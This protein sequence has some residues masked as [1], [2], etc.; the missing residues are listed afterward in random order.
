MILINVKFQPLP[1]NVD[2]FRELVTDFTDATRA[3]DGCLF[4]DWYRS[5]ENPA[6]Y[7]LV[8]GFEDDAAEA[9][10]TS[11]HFKRAQEYFPTILARTPQII[12]TLIEGKRDWDTM[13]E[14]TV[15]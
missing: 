12:N 3:E 9:H 15:E 7:I 2:N 10:V 11:A 14:F 6:E 5:E 4:F 13:A 8:E 1:E